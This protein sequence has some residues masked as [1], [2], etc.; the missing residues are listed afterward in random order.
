M[1]TD[2]GRAAAV[3]AMLAAVAVL[4]VGLLSPEWMG[5]SWAMNAVPTADGGAPAQLNYQG[6][7][8]D[9]AGQPV[10][11][12]SYTLTFALYDVE[13]GGTA[14]WA[15][16]QAVSV[17]GRACS[18]PGWAATQPI[19]P[20][21]VDGRALWLGITLAGEPEMA[22][23]QPL[24]SLPYALNAGD[25]RGA[26]IHPSTVSAGTYGL[27]IDA[28]GNWLG[29]PFP[30][31]PTGPTG[32]T[33]PAGPT[34]PTGSPGP[35]GLPDRRAPPV[36]RGPAERPAPT[37]RAVLRARRSQR[38][39]RPGER[40]APGCSTRHG[41]G[42]SAGH[43]TPGDHDRPAHRRVGKSHCP[44]HLRLGPTGQPRACIGGY[45][46]SSR[47]RLR[48]SAHRR[49]RPER[50]ADPA[51]TLGADRRRLWRPA[52]T[53]R[54]AA[55]CGARPRRRRLRRRPPTRGRQR[56]SAAARAHDA[57][58]D[59]DTVGGGAGSTRQRRLCDGSAA[60]CDER[61][62]QLMAPRSP[63]ATTNTAGGGARLDRRCV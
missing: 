15:E 60:A 40:L 54:H 5:E 13:A 14:L 44:A 61:R 30:A 10:P 62:Q 33:G 37:G 28:D 50:R 6:L 45:S 43:A 49:R 36:P 53:R 51:G 39:Y 24:A 18:T 29:Q 11:D 1:K 3:L 56:R 17:D 20:A 63:G 7:L 46:A 8:L 9:D 55:G 57:G 27:V 2:L 38:S 31:G 47:R 48:R 26:D 25:V 35:P 58:S 16:T 22:P 12:G 59:C 32:P 23:R 4:G 42:T 21:W 19:D 34:G 52:G 41:L